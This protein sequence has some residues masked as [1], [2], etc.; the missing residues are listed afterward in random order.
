M[1]DYIHD[2]RTPYF[3]RPVKEAMTP[4]DKYA[5]PLTEDEFMRWD[6]FL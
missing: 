6:A 1:T 2:P 5:E 3:S 4:T